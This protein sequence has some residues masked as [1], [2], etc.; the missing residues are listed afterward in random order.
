MMACPVCFGGEDTAM[1]ES[2]NAGIGVLLGVTAIVLGVLRA[3]LRRAGAA[4]AR[5]GALWSRA[6]LDASPSEQGDAVML[7]WLGL[8]VAASAHA[9]RSGS[10]HGPRPLADAACCSSAGAS[11]SS[12]CWCASA[13]GAQ[14]AG[15]LP[16]RRGRW[17]TWIEGGVLVAEIVLLA[18][19]SIPVLARATSTRMPPSSGAPMRPRRR[20]TVRLERP[21]SRAPTACSAARTSRWSTPDNPLGLDRDEPVGKDDII[22]DQPDEPAGGQAGRH[23]SLEQ[24]RDPQLRPAAD[25]REAGCDP[26]ASCSRCGSRRRR[27]ANGTSP[28]RSCAASATS[29]CEGMYAI[30]TQA[31]Y[32]AW[33]KEEADYLANP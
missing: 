29:A 31:D 9:G 15:R 33:L 5:G 14:P 28:A 16:R 22:D 27:P 12:T 7:E 2:L 21:L 8:P 13:R 30:Q 3:L 10:D 25:A 19:F 17:S 32:D 1:R 11:S 24:G 6:G 20:R 4:I 23:L 26:R 18:F